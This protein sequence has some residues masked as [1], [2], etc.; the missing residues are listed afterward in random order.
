[1]R[2]QAEVDGFIG[3]RNSTWKLV[4]YCVGVVLTGGALGLLTLWWPGMWPALTKKRAS[5]SDA[6]SFLVQVSHIPAAYARVCTR[7][8][9]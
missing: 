6:T 8:C 9:V 7:A 2:V 5:M 1:V 3:Y 4:A